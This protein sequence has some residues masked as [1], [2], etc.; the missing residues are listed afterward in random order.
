MFRPSVLLAT[1]LALSACDATEDLTPD[2]GPQSGEVTGEL[3]DSDGDGLSDNVEGQ[4]GTDP[5]STDSDADGLPDAAKLDLV[6][7]LG[8][9]DYTHTTVRFTVSRPDR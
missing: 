3:R 5:A 4:L 2:A 9:D 7:R 8:R 1:A 6:G